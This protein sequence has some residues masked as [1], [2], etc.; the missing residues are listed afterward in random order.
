[1]FSK[2]TP[3]TWHVSGKNSFRLFLQWFPNNSS[4]YYLRLLLLQVRK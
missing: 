2:R 4:C 3:S 1:M